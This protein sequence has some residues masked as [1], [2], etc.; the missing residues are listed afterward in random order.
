M[1]CSERVQTLRLET[2]LSAI[3]GLPSRPKEVTLGREKTHKDR[4]KEEDGELEVLPSPRG[5]GQDPQS[6]VEADEAANPG[7]GPIDGGALLTVPPQ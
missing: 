7:F 3:F 6:A 4:D 5:E 2:M 1:L